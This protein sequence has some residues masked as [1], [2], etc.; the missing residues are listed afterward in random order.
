MIGDLIFYIRYNVYVLL[1][2]I[3]SP[4]KREY[5]AFFMGK[6]PENFRHGFKAVLDL[7]SMLRYSISQSTIVARFTTTKKITE[8]QQTFNRVYSGYADT[9]FLFEVSKTGYVNFL[10]PQHY[11]HLYD[12]SIPQKP[13][14]ESLDRVQHFIDVITK[15]KREFMNMFNEIQSTMVEEPKTDNE[16]DDEITMEEIDPILDKIKE[17][18]ID[19]LT[20]KEKII[21]KKYT[22][23]D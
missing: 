16:H 13:I 21:L 6:Y 12:A 18:G 4:K 3:V 7:D 23:N 17:D 8:I 14:D 9:Y 1:K 19:S 10:C 2:K 5:I 15:M 11:K 22:K 20:E